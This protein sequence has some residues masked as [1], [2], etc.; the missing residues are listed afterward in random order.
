MLSLGKVSTG[1]AAAAYYEG[2]DDYYTADRSPSQWMGR[3]AEAL[4]LHGPVDAAMFRDLL[5]GKMPDGTQIH[6][7][8]EGRRGGTDFTLSAP[9][10]VSLQA[11]VGGDARLIDAHERAVARTLEYAQGLATYRVTQ[12]GVTRAEASGNLL[13]ASFRHDLSRRTDPQLHT[14]AVLINATQRP[15][16]AWRALEQ[17]EF[18]RQQKL[19]GALYRS[20]LALEVQRLGY[21]VARTHADGRFELGHITHAQVQAFSGR[22]K[23]IEAALARL[24]ETRQSASARQLHIATLATREAK[25][26][27][28]RVALREQWATASRELGIDYAPQLRA[29][30]NELGRASAAKAALDYAVA[31]ATERQAVVTQAR[32]LQAAIERGTGRT[33]LASIR[34]A[35]EGAVHDGRLLREHGRYTTEQAQRTE[36]EMLS[37]EARGRGAVAPTMAPAVAGERLAT[38]ELNV[39]QRAA[40]QAVLTTDARVLAVQGAAGT[41]KT[42]MLAAA[43]SELEARGFRVVG[44][45]PSAAATRELKQAGI[46]GQTLASFAARKGSGL[47]ARSVV[48]LDEAGMV[49]ARAMHGLLQKVE[50][51]DARLVLVGDVQQLKAVEA[52]RPFAQ[53]QAAGVA[54]VEL[55]EIQR[56]ADAQLR[57]AVELAAKGKIERSLALLERNVIEIDRS[58]ERHVA[59]ARQFVGL[60][61]QERE[62]TLVMAGT[63]AARTAINDAVRTEL[64][65]DRREQV[66]LTVLERKDLTSAQ[67]RSTV[68]Y[69]AGDV[70]Q[71][72]KEY[73]TLGL[74]RGQMATVV[75]HLPGRVV[76]ERADG[77]R[78]QWHPAVQSNML[79]YRAHERL[80]AA[81]DQLRFT[82]NDYALG[83]VNGDVGRVT[84]IDTGQRSLIVETKYGAVRLD[85][86][87]PLTIE[88]GYAS[89]VHGAQGR[90]ADRVLIDADTRS[91]TAN[92]SAF[93]VAISRARESVTIYTDDRSMLPAAMGRADEKTAALDLKVEGP[94]LGGGL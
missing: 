94:S 93:Y 68:S 50:A 37:I 43:R 49:S 87:N 26:E 90:T 31:H 16:G 58:G 20:E 76:L 12:D 54:R 13:V 63:H 84:A 18:Y 81:G 42:T 6:N 46:E 91:T 71:A 60:G 61:A 64:G 75:E 53:L 83:V 38:A 8:A 74:G 48:V 65:L 4:G 10:S 17:A 14:H 78:V 7:A 2:T 19:M 41:G 52:G 21:E 34:A 92:E 36:R 47:T 1:A 57:A 39:G 40:A 5:D 11:L 29:A 86:R 23:E 72:T 73:T 32:L 27:V 25:T 62:R 24:G 28:D 9:K 70:V 77:E 51:S 66:H 59:I 82:V 15:D 79:A 33:D 3:G 69:Q 30:P 35:V 45:A 56:Q 89:T 80:F 67:A 85:G 55:A 88:H 44:L 22:S